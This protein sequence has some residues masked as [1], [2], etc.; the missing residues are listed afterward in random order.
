MKNITIIV[1]LSL[2]LAIIA[3]FYLNSKNQSE[4]IA[5]YEILLKE[6]QKDFF[7]ST[8]ESNKEI[9]PNI[10]LFS[11]FTSSDVT[12]AQ[13]NFVN[14][15]IIKTPQEACTCY[16]KQIMMLDTSFNN[17][18]KIFLITS[19]EQ[20]M[21]YIDFV[22]SYNGNIQVYAT[23]EKINTLLENGLR[24]YCFYFDNDYILKSVFI[25][26][27]NKKAIFDYA[28]HITEIYI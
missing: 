5:E 3:K 25:L 11:H 28:K 13:A 8:S 20:Y 2:F 7:I 16:K 6:L 24:P 26:G 18:K 19:P 1:A 27:H 14:S 15:L 23:N 4:D 22:K 9:N 21:E 10:L 17:H 12:L